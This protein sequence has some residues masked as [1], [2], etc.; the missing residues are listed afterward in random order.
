MYVF[1]QNTGNAG[2]LKLD[3]CDAAKSHIFLTQAGDGSKA[4]LAF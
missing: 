1:L 3:S 4:W 2:L